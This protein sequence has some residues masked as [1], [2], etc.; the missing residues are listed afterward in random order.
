LP[1]ENRGNMEEAEARQREK[2]ESRSEETE[3]KQLARPK[4]EHD[5]AEPLLRIVRTLTGHRQTITSVALARDGNTLA[6]TCTRWL[7]LSPE[8]WIWDI[9]KSAV[10]TKLASH[11]AGLVYDLAFSPDGTIL[12]SGGIG[13]IRLWS[14]PDGKPLRTLRISDRPG[15]SGYDYA[16][17]GVEFASVAFSPDGATLAAAADEHDALVRLWRCADGEPLRIFEKRSINCT[18]TSLTYSP[19]G[20]FLAMAGSDMDVQIWHVPNWEYWSLGSLKGGVSGTRNIA[21]SPDGA[22]FAAG[23]RLWRASDWKLIGTL[24]ANEFDPRR[25]NHVA[26]SPDNALLATATTEN[27][28]QIWRVAD[29]RLLYRQRWPSST[30]CLTWSPDRSLLIPVGNSIHLCSWGVRH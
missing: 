27:A 6:S 20:T 14:M 8:L 17:S 24:E 19:N 18:I 2:D 12:A 21:F 22:L 1:P 13:T 5:S 9:G 4:G 3:A 26:F 29:K 25:V 15:A 30:A 28:V 7:I 23:A 10:R 11:K 16:G